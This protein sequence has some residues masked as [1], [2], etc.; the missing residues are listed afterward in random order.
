MSNTTPER[1]EGGTP[2]GAALNSHSSNRTITMEQP[3]EQIN[4]KPAPDQEEFE[5]LAIRMWRAMTEVERGGLTDDWNVLGRTHREKHLQKLAGLKCDEML[6]HIEARERKNAEAAAKAAAKAAVKAQAMHPAVASEAVVD[7]HEPKV[8]EATVQ[9]V[10]GTPEAAGTV[11]EENSPEV[12]AQPAGLVKRFPS[13]TVHRQPSNVLPNKKRRMIHNAR[14]RETALQC[15]AIGLPVVDVHSIDDDGK[16]T[17]Q[18]GNEKAIAEGRAPRAPCGRDAGKHPRGQAWQTSATTNPEHIDARWVDKP[19]YVNVGVVFGGPTRVVLVEADGALGLE[20]FARWNAEEDGGMPETLTCISGSG[21]I[22]RY[23]RVPEGWDMRNSSTTIGTKVDVRGKHGFSVT[24]GS[25]HLSGFEAGWKDGVGVYKWMEGRG[26]GEIEIADMPVWLLRKV[27]FGT[28]DRRHEIAPDGSKWEDAKLPEPPPAPDEP[29]APDTVDPNDPFANFGAAGSSGG[30]W[31]AK[32][33]LIGHGEGL[34]SFDGQIYSAAC[35]Y[36][37]TFGYEA[38]VEPLKAKLLER[39][40]IA[41]EDTPGH[42]DRY[43]T[44][45]YLDNRIEQ[46]RDYAKSKG[47]DAT[48]AKGPLDP[49]PRGYCASDGYLCWLRPGATKDGETVMEP[50]P[51]TVLFEVVG[52]TLDETREFGIR[53]PDTVQR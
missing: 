46:A 23:Y 2:T 48:K 31:E 14:T 7:G 44:D 1:D 35:S 36:F 27:W 17:C 25:R 26:P 16:C 50:V 29:A 34:K 47:G 51:M 39:I 30:G 22:H 3:A 32:V 33:E 40:R 43:L 41:P 19:Y 37:G 49:W 42:R 12:A 21:G 18:W 4:E 13:T 53:H 5:A 38:E 52:R 11:C 24:A 10:E 9:P 15:I 6:P 8:P 45:E 20:T 28:V